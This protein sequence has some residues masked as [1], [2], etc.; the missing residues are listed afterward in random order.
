MSLLEEV[1]EQTISWRVGSW[2]RQWMTVVACVQW[3]GEN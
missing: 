1:L 3:C 2:V